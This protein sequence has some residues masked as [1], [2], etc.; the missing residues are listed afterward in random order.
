VR[1]PDGARAFATGYRREEAWPAD[2]IAR[3]RANAAR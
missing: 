1:L 2:K 3:L